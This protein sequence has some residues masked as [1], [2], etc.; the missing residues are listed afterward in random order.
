MPTLGWIIA[1]VLDALFWLW[2]IFGGGAERIE[3]S[4]LSTLVGGRWEPQTSA[5]ATKLIGWITLL[6]STAWFILG[7][8]NPACRFAD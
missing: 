2:I 3:G 8:F 7:I 4:F 6:G 1:Y 5:D